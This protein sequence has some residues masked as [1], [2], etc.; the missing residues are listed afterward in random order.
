[1][2]NGVYTSGRTK[3]RVEDQGGF[4]EPSGAL[5]SYASGATQLDRYPLKSNGRNG[6]SN[7]DTCIMI[8]KGAGTIKTTHYSQ[9][10]RVTCSI[11]A[12]FANVV[13]GGSGSINQNLYT[14]STVLA[15]SYS[16]MGSGQDAQ[17]AAPA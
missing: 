8:F 4:Y 9:N 6:G 13:H 3:V 14:E 7:E 10:G 17:S 15:K 11:I 2:K 5:A 12:P 1:M 16:V